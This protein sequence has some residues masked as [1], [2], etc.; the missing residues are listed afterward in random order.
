MQTIKARI[1]VGSD[2]TLSVQ[3][4]ADVPVG[5]YEVVLV[6]NPRLVTAVE[7]LVTTQKSTTEAAAGRIPPAS[8][9]GKGKALGDIVSPIVTE[10]DWECLK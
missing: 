10:E 9:V 2:R 3:L 8:I 7:E 1:R 6:L 4:P 5:E